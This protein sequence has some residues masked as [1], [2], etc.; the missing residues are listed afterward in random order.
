MKKTFPFDPENISNKILNIKSNIYLREK[1][2]QLSL[3]T[4]NFT[5]IL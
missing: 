5:I 2:N 1:E 4:F 3:E